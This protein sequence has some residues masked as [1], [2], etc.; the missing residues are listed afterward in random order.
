MEG[1]F[2]SDNR[3]VKMLHDAASG[4]SLHVIEGEG[5]QFSDVR[6]VAEVVRLLITEDNPSSIYNCVDQEIIT[7]EQ[8]ASLVLKTLNLDKNLCVDFR[9]SEEDLPYFL[10]DQVESLV[11]LPSSSEQTLEEHIQHLATMGGYLDLAETLQH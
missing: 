1:S 7:W 2:R 5:R 10:T 4:H 8:I 9:N 11:K 3:I 6:L